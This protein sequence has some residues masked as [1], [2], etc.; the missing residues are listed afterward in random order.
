M[1]ERSVSWMFDNIL[2]TSTGSR[3]AFGEESAGVIERGEEVCETMEDATELIESFA[4]QAG[5]CC[6]GRRGAGSVE[7]VY[8]A[9]IEGRRSIAAC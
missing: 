6:E 4:C 1:V 8:T 5:C 2:Y 7:V 3:G 9:G